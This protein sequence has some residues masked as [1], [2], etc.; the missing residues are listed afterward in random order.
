MLEDDAVLHDEHH[1]LEDRDVLQ[2]VTRHGHDIG[3]H[4]RGEMAD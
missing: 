3:Q 2:R 1:L 4:S